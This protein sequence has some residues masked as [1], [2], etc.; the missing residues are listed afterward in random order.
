METWSE[1][2]NPGLSGSRTLL[3]VQLHESGPSVLDEHCKRPLLIQQ[4]DALP[5]NEV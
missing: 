2:L 1:V 3:F 5:R 4:E